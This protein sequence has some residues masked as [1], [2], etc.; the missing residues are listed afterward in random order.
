[1]KLRKYIFLIFIIS[2]IVY[3]NSI[4]NP[5]IWDDFFLI[6]NNYL[7]KNI[8]NFFVFFKTPLYEAFGDDSSFYRPLQSISYCLIYKIFKLNPVGYHLLNI[9]LHTFCAILF[10]ILLKEIYGEKISFLA[11]LLWAVHPINTEAVTYISG[12][13]DPL[14]LFFGLLCIYFYNLYIFSNFEGKK[15]EIFFIFSF[16]SFIFSLLSKEMAVIIPFLLLLYIWTKNEKINRKIILFFVL[17]IIYG[18][19][20][21]TILKFYKGEESFFSIRFFT[22]FKSFIYYFYLLL[23]PKVLSMGRSFS[24]VISPFD[25]WFISGFILF[26]FSVFIV[27]RHKEN[28]KIIFPYLL[29]LI[30]FFAISGIFI[31]LNAYISEHFLY[32][33]GIGLLIYIVLLLEKIKDKRIKTIAIL[34]IVLLCGTRTILRNYD[35]KDPE[36]FYQKSINAG[37]KDK[38]IYYNLAVVYLNKGEYQK[39]LEIFKLAENL[40]KEKKLVYLGIGKS[41]YNLKKYNE[42]LDYFLKILKDEPYEPQALFF[43]AKIYYETGMKKLPEIIEILNI[44]IEKNP[45]YIP[46]YALTGRILF[47]NGR[48]QESI[49]YLEKTVFMNPDDDMASVFLGISYFNTGNTHMAEKYLKRAYFL[50]PNSLMI[51]LNLAFLYKSTGRYTEAIEL[52]EKVIKINPDD[53]DALNDLALCYAMIGEK[54]KAKNIWEEIL[55][56]NPDYQ[57][58]IMNLKIL[59]GE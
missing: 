21:L 5:F 28:R 7:I 18:I 27:F 22:S 39:A 34:I 24:P 56:K 19:L 59:Q 13:A 38:K 1:M 9:F 35:W 50:N 54:A 15:K 14:F 26:C 55:K 29:Y 23:F 16:I 52:Y 45:A 44:C 11:S 37:F 40:Y 42:A 49:K 17:A 47:E 33:G 2:I 53:L 58:A 25:L 4:F 30:N 8:N 12:T 31:N 43:V 57:P 3:F 48:Y 46:A 20:R 10:Y 36:K 41:F 51:I 32:A 6:K